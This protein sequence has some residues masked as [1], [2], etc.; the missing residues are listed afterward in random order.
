MITPNSKAVYGQLSSRFIG[1]P[2]VEKTR[3][4]V[5]GGRVCDKEEGALS[6]WCRDLE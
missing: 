6:S 2:V 1:Q 5:P 3:C 4:D